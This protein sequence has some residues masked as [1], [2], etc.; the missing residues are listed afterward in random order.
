MKSLTKHWAREMGYPTQILSTAQVSENWD[1]CLERLKG[2]I[3]GIACVTFSPDGKTIASASR[4]GRISLLDAGSRRPLQTLDMRGEIVS[5]VFSSDGQT[6]ASLSPTTQV[7]LWDTVSG[8]CLQCYW[9]ERSTT[10]ASIERLPQGGYLVIVARGGSIELIELASGYPSRFLS[11]SLKRIASVAFSPDGKVIVATGKE[12][13]GGLM[14]YWDT[15]SWTASESLRSHGKTV[16]AI[17]FSP[18]SKL[19]ASGSDDKTVKLWDVDK[20]R[21][22]LESNQNTMSDMDHGKK[23]KLMAPLRTYKPDID[24]L[25]IAFSPDSELLA[26]GGSGQIRLVDVG[27]G[28]MLRCFTTHGTVYTLAFSPD[29]QTL[30]SGG[31]SAELRLWDVSPSNQVQHKPGYDPIRYMVFSPDGQRLA[32]LSKTWNLW[33]PSSGRVLREVTMPF[34]EDY[35]VAFSP[36]GELL[37]VL[38]SYKTIKLLDANTGRTLRTMKVPTDIFPAGFTHTTQLTF[39][40]DSRDIEISVA[41]SARTRTM[42]HKYTDVWLRHSPLKR[43]SLPPAKEDSHPASENAPEANSLRRT[44]NAPIYSVRS[45]WIYCQNHRVLWLSPDYRNDIFAIH[46]NVVALSNSSGEVAILKFLK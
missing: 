20:C 6:L 35:A 36:D 38:V 46:G 43:D 10:T 14:Q 29:R 4:E 45:D 30:V 16:R 31:A 41:S 24:I 11:T 42:T 9:G 12:E 26:L 5:I 33:D 21:S 25:A 3:W 2:H 1:P 22:L 13:V 40:G 34:T 32:S 17:T 37:A 27:S 7:Q 23:W 19:L 15:E 28:H 18:N 8:T 39:S 44:L